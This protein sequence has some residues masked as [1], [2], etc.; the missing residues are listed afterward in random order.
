MAEAH[1][2]F[3]GLAWLLQSRNVLRSGRFSGYSVSLS[4]DW[5]K[6]EGGIANE[7]LSPETRGTTMR[8]MPCS[9][10]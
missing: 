1:V 10:A 5:Y 3:Y 6:L 2:H 9:A 8:V 4:I 7:A